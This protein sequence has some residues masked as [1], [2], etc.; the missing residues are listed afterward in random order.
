[1]QTQNQNRIQI[2][3]ILTQA[4]AYLFGS[5]FLVTFKVT[6]LLDWVLPAL[7]YI[8]FAVA[9]FLVIAPFCDWLMKWANKIDYYLSGGLFA[10]TLALLVKTV[11]D[12]KSQGFMLLSVLVVIW[13][14]LLYVVLIFLLVRRR[15]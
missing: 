13:V 1:M 5:A 15:R 11:I 3:Y 7:G 12:I 4:F 2:A 9:I 10:V 6:N 8:F 14:I